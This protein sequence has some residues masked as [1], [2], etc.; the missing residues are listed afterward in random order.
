MLLRPLQ[1]IALPTLAL[2]WLPTTS[3]DTSHSR[4]RYRCDSPS[5]IAPYRQRGRRV[6]MSEANRTDWFESSGHG[7]DRPGVL[8]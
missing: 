3:A 5:F 6:S 8:T 2:P 7:R 4:F 1:P